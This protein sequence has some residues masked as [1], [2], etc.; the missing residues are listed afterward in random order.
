MTFDPILAAPPVIQI[1][2]AAASLAL[3]L[4][5]LPLLRKRYDRLHKVAGYVWVTAMAV[6][7]LTAFG[8]HG[9]AL[10]GPFSPIHLL[11]V[12]TLVS[13]VTGIRYVIKGNIR[14]H[15]ATMTN[16]YLRGLVL[17][18]LFNVLPGRTVSRMLFPEQPEL[19]WLVIALGLSALILHALA[20]LV[21]GR[22]LQRGRALQTI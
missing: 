7:A 2:A 22:K 8:I 9:V 12:L 5:P 15:R 3:L 10:I 20:P 17:A 16:L 21:K 19:G 18:G 11:A 4:G 6:T 1:H 14:A 13:L